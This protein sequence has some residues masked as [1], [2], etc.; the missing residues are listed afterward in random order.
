M[1]TSTRTQ[2]Q[3]QPRLQPVISKTKLRPT[4]SILKTV[5]CHITLGSFGNCYYQEIEVAQYSR[6]K[7]VPD[8]CTCWTMLK[9]AYMNTKVR[10]ACLKFLEIS[11]MFKVQLRYYITQRLY[12]EVLAYLTR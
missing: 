10:K 3:K 8:F 12:S 11:E 1:P 5:L 7:V 9:S 2:N 6:F 4:L